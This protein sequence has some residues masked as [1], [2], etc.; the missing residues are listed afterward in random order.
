MSVSFLRMI[1]LTHEVQTLKSCL[2]CSLVSLKKRAAPYLKTAN[3][4]SGRDLK[5]AR[6]TGADSMDIGRK[7]R[8]PI[9]VLIQVLTVAVIMATAATRQV[10]Y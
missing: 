9:Q 1:G 3:G 8:M 7:R 2:H 6:H 5:T 10:A 4:V